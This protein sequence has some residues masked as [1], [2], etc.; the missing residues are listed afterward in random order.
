MRLTEY[1]EAAAITRWQLA[2]VRA[3]SPAK[4]RSLSKRQR[5]MVIEIPLACIQ[6]ANVHVNF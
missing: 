6:R 4:G 5:D 2:D 3:N 1:D